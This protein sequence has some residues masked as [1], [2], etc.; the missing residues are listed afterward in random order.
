MQPSG[1][2]E[3]NRS[4]LNWWLSC[5]AMTLMASLATACG[6][7]AAGGPAKSADESTDDADDS[8]PSKPKV[9]KP[10][11]RHEHTYHRP[12]IMSDIVDG[13][14][15]EASH[16]TLF[17]GCSGTGKSVAARAIADEL[18]MVL[19][20]ANCNKEMTFADLAGDK[21]VE[22]DEKTAQNHIVFKS[23]IL[24]D[25]H[26]RF[27]I[28]QR[29]GLPFATVAQ[30]FKDRDAA[31]LWV[32]TNQVGRRNLTRYQRV[33]L[34]LVAKP[35]LAAQAKERLRTAHPGVRGGSPVQKSSQGIEDR[36][37]RTKIAT[38]AGVSHDTI[39]KVEVLS[40]RATPETKVKLRTGDVTIHKAYTDVVQADRRAARV[41]RVLAHAGAPDL[42]TLQPVPVLYA[43]PPWRYEASPTAS[44]A[45]ENHYDTMTLDDICA[46]PVSA[47]ATPDAVLFLWAPSPKLAEAQQVIT[48]WGFT[49]RTSAVWVKCFGIL[50]QATASWASRSS[51]STVSPLVRHGSMPQAHRNL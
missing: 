33:E 4:R 43:D 35:I 27:A 18:G 3:A 12:K 1:T 9:K 36:K 41:A 5:V 6:G 50:G 2:T 19:H 32:I 37:T 38:L 47:A 15:D 11:N 46:L 48:A 14:G 39:H 22:I 10:D 26:H 25:G 8:E 13:L 7:G 49:H 24:L 34:A 21:T 28:C 42:T 20:Q 40:E 17:T 45:I 51:R 23:G 31:L 16:V 29:D 30:S 44:R